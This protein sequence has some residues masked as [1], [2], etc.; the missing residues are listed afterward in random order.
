M[1]KD[2]FQNY[3]VITG[4]PGVGKTTLLNKLKNTGNHIIPEDARHIIQQQIQINGEALP[5]KNKT[6]YAELMFKASLET[7]QNVNIDAFDKTVFFDRG[8]LDSIC[9][10]EMEKISISD[11][12]LT[13]ARLHPYNEKV[14]ILPPWLEIYEQDSERKQSWETAEYTFDQMRKTYLNFGYKLIEVPRATP[15]E[16][17]EFVLNNI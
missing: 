8:I 4:G 17:C 16:R 7:Y 14:F 11:E 1:I 5:W 10:M 9:Y 15:E 3:F 2:K 6:L 12:M 13:I